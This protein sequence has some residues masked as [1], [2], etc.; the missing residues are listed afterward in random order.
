VCDSLL[1]PV[2]RARPRPVRSRLKVA[3]VTP[4]FP[5]SAVSYRGHSAFHTLRFLKDYAD[6]NVICPLA[7]YPQVPGLTPKTFDQ[8]D[9]TYRPPGIPTRYFQYP[10][11]PVITRPVN[12]FICLQY[13]MP[14]LEQS[15][16][17]VILNYWL[18]P[19]GYAALRAGRKLGI[20]VIV[21]SIGSDL[22]RIPDAVTRYLVRRTVSEA[23][24]VLTVSEDLRRAAIGLGALPSNVTA[25]LNGC[26]TSVFHPGD[27]PQARRTLGCDPSEKVILFVGSLLESKGLGELIE[28]FA[29][30]SSAR[31]DIR[32]VL[33]GEGG[34]RPVLEQKAKASGVADRVRLLG[35]QP[36]ATVADWIRAADLLCLPSH[37]EGCPNVI[38]EALA[39]GLP[40]V[41]TEVGGIPELVAPECG[42]LV[43]PRQAGALRAALDAAMARDW[44]TRVIAGAFRRSWQDVAEETLELCTEV[45]EEARHSSRPGKE[46]Q[47]IAV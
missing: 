14:F 17:D 35:R 45:V 9:L 2:R 42:I 26:D 34:Y 11:V 4:Y 32:L 5:T 24:A 18:Y 16:P 27:R 38:V 8:P 43:A 13:L 31:T 21:G 3:V 37:S 36:S 47:G 25:I 23:D 15:R 7:T 29:A 30:L 6:V 40:I 33:I 39:C 19:E 20:P 12:G 22:R 1:K 10:A 28:A 44:D 41:A 46:R